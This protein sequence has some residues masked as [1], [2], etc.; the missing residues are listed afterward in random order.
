VSLAV[1]HLQNK[2]LLHMEMPTVRLRRSRYGEL[3]L[4]R[5]AVL[6]LLRQP[7][8]YTELMPGIS[9]RVV[10]LLRDT[11]WDSEFE[12]LPMPVTTSVQGILPGRNRSPSRHSDRKVRKADVRPMHACGVPSQ[13]C[14]LI[15]T[16]R[17]YRRRKL[18]H[19]LV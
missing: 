10:P 3:S 14:R 5:E 6:A 9:E 19:G 11:V 12:E 16:D 2:G 17:R 4:D 13:S 1:E 7:M 15:A 18:M 8:I